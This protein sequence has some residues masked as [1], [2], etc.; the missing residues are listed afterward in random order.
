VRGHADLRVRVA[1]GRDGS[2]A[3]QEGNVVPRQRDRVPTELAE[4]P[5]ALVPRGRCCSNEALVG[6]PVAAGMLHGRPDT[7][8][9]G[10]LVGGLRGRKRRAG[11]LLGIESVVELLRRVAPDRQGALEGLCLEGVAKSRH[12]AGHEGTRARLRSGRVEAGDV[13]DIHG[14]LPMNSRNRPIAIASGSRH[15]GCTSNHSRQ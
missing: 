5:V 11:E 10:A 3:G 1:C 9:P 7:I 8:E 14:A 12:V 13:L 2:Q 15:I 6:P 4:R